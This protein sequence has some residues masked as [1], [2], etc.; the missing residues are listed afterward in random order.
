MW[1]VTGSK[2]SFSLNEIQ[3]IDMKNVEIMRLE[4]CG[5]ENLLLKA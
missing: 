4:W 1:T 5:E 3:I 2:T